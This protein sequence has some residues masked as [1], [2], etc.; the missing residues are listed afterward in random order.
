MLTVG[1]VTLLQAVENVTGEVLLPEAHCNWH[2]EESAYL[3]ASLGKKEKEKC[4]T[5][6]AGSHKSL[7]QAM[8]KGVKL[9]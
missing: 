3:K 7:L 4:E 9:L 5:C 8:K 2:W 1:L 6:Y